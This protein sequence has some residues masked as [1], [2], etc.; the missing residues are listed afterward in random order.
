[1]MKLVVGVVLLLLVV[2]SSSFPAADWTQ[3]DEIAALDAKAQEAVAA[4]LHDDALHHLAES[5]SLKRQSLVDDADDTH[6]A[7]S[8]NAI[9]YVHKVMGHFVEARE[10]Y[11]QAL[12]LYEKAG[13]FTAVANILVNM[14]NL[15][16]AQVSSEE[17]VVVSTSQHSI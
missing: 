9:G 13:E 6:I 7:Q 17:E 10:H 12:A 4:G 3:D 8:L 5:V 11:D 15:L 16:K 1:M 2:V 14:A